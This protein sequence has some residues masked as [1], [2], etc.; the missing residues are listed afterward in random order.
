MSR[1]SGLK[2]RSRAPINIDVN[3]PRAVAVCDGCG[4]WTMHNSL[5]EKHDYRGGV[6][7]VGLNLW[8]CGVCDD[9][10]NPYFSKM[11]LGPDPVPVRNPRPE[12]YPANDPNKMLFICADYNTPIITGV[13]PQNATNNGFNFLSG[14]NP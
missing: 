10:P 1:L 12:A 14:N 9:V 5:V 13:N 11:V 7:P 6:T 2:L 3:N 4:M 8:V